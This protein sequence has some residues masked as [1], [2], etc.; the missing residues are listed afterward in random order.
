MAYA[1]RSK[2][3]NGTQVFICQLIFLHQ[4]MHICIGII[5][6]IIII[7]KIIAIIFSSSAAQLG[8]WPPRI[9]RFL[10]HTKRRATGLLWTSDQPVAET[11]N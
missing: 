6:I 8:L 10:N 5:I 3:I 1:A 11:F 2:T 4:P 7:I 9:T